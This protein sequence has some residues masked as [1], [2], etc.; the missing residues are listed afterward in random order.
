M[1]ALYDTIG[2]DYAQ[3]RRPD[4]RIGHMIHTALG[5]A[6]TVINIGA[7]SGSYEPADRHVTA[8]E[9]SDVMIRQRPQ[10]NARVIQCSAED[11]PFPDKSFD[12]SMA[13]LTL[14][15]WTNLQKG[16]DEMRRVTREKMV[17][18]THDPEFSDFWL[19][20]YFP[21]LKAS[22]KGRMPTMADLEGWLG[23]CRISALPVPSD[24]TDGFVAAY[25]RRPEAYLDENVRA[26]M[27]PFRMIGQRTSSGLRQ[28][29]EDLQSGHWHERNGFLMELDELDCGYRLIEVTP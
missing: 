9:P 21:E 19:L 20:D 6:K 4:E 5:D 29:A 24:C 2:L 10:S 17:I 7:G 12:A 3:M 23:K 15:H 14:H 27:S 28:L 1:T 13:V 16:L 11:L 22:D 18:M 8:I 26:A 25:W